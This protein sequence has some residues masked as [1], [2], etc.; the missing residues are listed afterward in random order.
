MAWR[1]GWLLLGAGLSFVSLP[2][3][4]LFGCCR[5]VDPSDGGGQE[6]QIALDQFLKLHELQMAFV[7]PDEPLA[8]AK[9]GS[10]YTFASPIPQEKPD[11]GGGPE[12]VEPRLGPPEHVA[13]SQP[14]APGLTKREPLVEALQ[15]ILEDRHKEALAHLQA[16]DAE[17]QEFYLRILPALTILA[18]KRLDNFTSQEVAVLNEQLQ[19]LLATLRPRTEL[20]IERMCYCVAVKSFGVY[21][22]LEEGHTFAA[23]DRP[24]LGE[25]V[26]LYAEVRNFASVPFGNGFET[27]LRSRLEIRNSEGKIVWENDKFIDEKEPVRTSSRLSD[28][29]NTYWFATPPLPP[30]TYQLVLLVADETLPGTR[31]V[32]ERS[33][34]FRV[35]PSGMRAR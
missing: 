10:T 13:A 17:T 23:G 2:G 34:E 5:H 6:K 35:T 1:V 16:F 28:F 15:C 14:P 7:L 19:S 31:R 18:R 12:A 9:S 11:P 33:L 29:Y 32:A 24:G 22:P 8:I 4:N 30:G 25:P 20:I 27:H 26:R 21:L 3:C